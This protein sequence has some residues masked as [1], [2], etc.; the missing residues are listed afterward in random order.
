[1]SDVNK[2]AGEVRESFTLLATQFEHLEELARLT[3]SKNIAGPTAG[4]TSWRA[5]LRR[6]AKGD[7]DK[8]LLG[9]GNDGQ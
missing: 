3:D 8:A 9:K 5:L 1:M 2:V 6:M 4:Q 7:F